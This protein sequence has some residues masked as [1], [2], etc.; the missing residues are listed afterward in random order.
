MC[1]SLS[2]SIT[3]CKDNPEIRTWKSTIC[4]Y[5]HL[6]AEMRRKRSITCFKSVHKFAYMNGF[7][8]HEICHHLL[9]KNLVRA[10]V[11]HAIHPGR[12]MLNAA[13]QA[14][15]TSCVSIE[16]VLLFSICDTPCHK[17]PYHTFYE[18]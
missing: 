7:G 2:M 1:L 4:I 6:Y 17:Q 16:H 15:H 8:L 9:T 11:V 3:S 5:A 12:A 13:L 10:C 14:C 18:N